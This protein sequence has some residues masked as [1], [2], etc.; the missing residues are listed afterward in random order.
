L[1]GHSILLFDN[2][3]F[4]D[5]SRSD[6]E[7]L[8]QIAAF[9]AQ[10][11]QEGTKLA[12]IIYMHRISDMRVGGI[13]VRNIRMFEELCGPSPLKNVAI[14]TTMW[15]PG[16]KPEVGERREK[17]LASDER[18]FKFALDNGAHLLRH[19]DEADVG[20]A[21]AIIRSFFKNQ[22]EAMCIQRELVDEGKDISQTAAGEVLNREFAAKLKLAEEN[23]RRDMKALED[24][25]R[26]S[27]EAD[28]T[29]INRQLSD[30]QQRYDE[31]RQ[32]YRDPW[33]SSGEVFRSVSN[34]VGN[35]NVMDVM[36][37]QTFLFF[38][39]TYPV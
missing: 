14:V 39:L 5:T 24:R 34:L 12:G 32:I 2:P 35:D 26:K 15:G 27:V 20:S 38:A 8:T 16:I 30:V 10:T 13:S 17:Q 25:L 22:P 36:E 28:K 3:G 23:L 19:V 11:Y 31:T 4:D 1:D 33:R 9:L 7:I 29:A 21:Q 6:T 37:R 18:F